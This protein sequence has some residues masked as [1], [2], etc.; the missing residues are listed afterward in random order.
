MRWYV[1]V[2]RWV[3]EVAGKLREVA[4]EGGCAL[5][6]M[7]HNARSARPGGVG[8]MGGALG[9]GGAGGDMAG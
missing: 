7:F 8:K 4:K 1:G 5:S 6:L 2:G 3:G 9:C